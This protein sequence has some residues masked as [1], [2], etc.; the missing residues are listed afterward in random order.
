MFTHDRVKKAP[1]LAREGD[2]GR[3][4]GNLLR[5]STGEG[6]SMEPQPRGEGSLESNHR[7]KKGVKKFTRGYVRRQIVGPLK[8]KG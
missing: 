2:R 5:G 8:R 6:E 1:T 4:V 7:G 3:Q